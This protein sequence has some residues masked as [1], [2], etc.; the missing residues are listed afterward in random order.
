MEDSKPKSASEQPRFVQSKWETVHPE[1]VEAQAM[2]ISKWEQ[3][4]KENVDGDPL[5]EETTPVR[6]FMSVRKSGVTS[7]IL[8]VING[9]VLR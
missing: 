1:E 8:N 9:R 6:D 4:E 7:S 2:T 5:E 3:L